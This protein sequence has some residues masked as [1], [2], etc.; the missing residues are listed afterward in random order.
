MAYWN[1]N[2]EMNPQGSRVPRGVYYPA[3]VIWSFCLLGTLF[4]ALLARIRS[5]EARLWGP[6][7]SVVVCLFFTFIE[8]TSWVE[9]APPGKLSQLGRA[10]WQE[11]DRRGQADEPRLP[12]Q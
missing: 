2:D 12:S 5:A 9:I 6:S 11:I 3:V 8:P 7:L 1:G 4:Q 10:G